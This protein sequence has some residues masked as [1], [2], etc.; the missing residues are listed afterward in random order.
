MP[1]NEL[2]R[3]PGAS[4]G[5]CGGFYAAFITTSFSSAGCWLKPHT[6][7]F[8]LSLHSGQTTDDEKA[9][10][11]SLMMMSMAFGMDTLSAHARRRTVTHAISEN[12]GE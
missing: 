1:D 12:C 2:N 11:N 6:A 5:N 4:R 10:D 9:D 3:A 8:V 7:H